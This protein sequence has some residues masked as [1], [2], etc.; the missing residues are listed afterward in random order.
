MTIDENTSNVQIHVDRGFDRFRD[1]EYE[2]AVAYF[3]EAV[4]LDPRNARAFYGRGL[5]RYSVR[6]FESAAHDYDESIRL[7]PSEASVFLS[8]GMLRFQKREVEEAIADYT[9]SIRLDPKSTHAYQK[10]GDAWLFGKEF[11][12]ARADLEEVVRLDPDNAKAYLQI[13]LAQKELESPDQALASLSEAIRLDPRMIEAFRK[14]GLLF[15]ERGDEDRAQHD[16]ERMRALE[17]ASM[18]MGKKDVVIPAL[19]KAHFAPEP[20]NNL[21]IIERT[22]PFRVRADLQR[23]LDELFKGNTRISYFCG[24][25]R[26]YVSDGLDFTGLIVPSR[27]EPPL[28]VPPQYEEIDIGE[29]RPVRCL[30][31]GLW[32]LECDESRFAVLLGPT[33]GYGMAAELK[34][35]LASVNCQDGTRITQKFFKHL[36]ESVL[37][38][39]SYR[40]KVLSLEVKGRYSGESSGLTVHQLPT[41]SRSDVILAKETLEL[42]DR[43]AV[44]F[45]RRR[46]RFRELGFPTKKGLLFYGPPGTGKTHTIHYLI[47]ALEG[48]T[49]FLISAEQVGLFD[50]Y[51]MLARLLQPSVVVLEDVDLIARDRNQV[52]ASNEAMLN[53]L[54]NEMDGLRPDAD[55]LFILTTNR[56]E[57]LESALASRPG[58][59]DQAIE[60]PLPTEEARARLIRLYSRGLSL[61]DDVIEATVRKTEN[62]SASFIKEL[63]RRAAQFQIERDSSTQD[64]T[65]ED[66]ENALEELLFTGGSLN[67]KLLGAEEFPGN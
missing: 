57:S 49:T 65:I 27:H 33:G 22:Y 38:S 39:K 6:D 52:G 10:R 61:A 11:E 36:E 15:A 60:F 47:Q 56:P 32:L 50:E 7:D 30:K 48:H 34:L 8:R 44:E 45:T 54:L 29:E 2:A 16:L 24:I 26:R 53:R 51:M 40:G 3:D 21:T 67:R 25:S 62:V 58:R 35:Q 28:S 12:K 4:R 42:L 66:I 14:R 23:A 20:I 9:E 59:V 63:L 64:T 18:T 55:V 1:Q 17:A 41:I 37:E 46:A 19:I 43:N 5:A 13:G 31:N